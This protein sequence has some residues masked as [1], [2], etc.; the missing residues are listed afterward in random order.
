[1]SIL[2]GCAQQ[3]KYVS[4]TVKRGET[5]K[6]IAKDNGMKS[7]DLLRLNPDVSKRPA[8]N[9]V[10]IIPNKNYNP[11]AEEVTGKTTHRVLRQE[12]LFSISQ[13]YGITVDALKEANDLIGNSISVGRVLIIPAKENVDLEEIQEV[14]IDSTLITHTV[15]KDD[16]IYNLTKLYEITEDELMEMN[17]TL[18]D[19]LN[20]GM[21]LIVGRI[22]EETEEDLNR[23]KDSIT[24]KQLNILLMLPYKLK[25]TTSVETLFEKRNSLLNIVTDFHSGALIAIDSLRSQGM[26]VN[27]DVVDTENNNNK[28]AAILR[29]T[30]FDEYDAVIGPLFLKNAKTVSRSV[31]IP[32]IAPIFSKTQTTVSDNNL[33]KVAPNKELLESKVMDYMLENYHGE[34][35]IVTGDASTATSS[36]IARVVAK[37]KSHD[38]INDVTVIRQEEGYIKKEKFIEAIDTVQYKNWVLLVGDDNITTADVVNNLGVMPLELRDIRLFSFAMGTNFNNVSNTHLVRLNFTYSDEEFIDELSV[39]TRSFERMYKAKNYVRPSYYATKGFDVTYDALLRLS[40]YDSFNE[41]AEAGVS[42]RVLTKF[43]YTKRWFGST[44]NLGVYLLQYQEGLE[45]KVIE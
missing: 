42:E 5:I 27:I 40:T 12:N 24:D 14:A 30:D 18:V 19:G 23:F 13:K 22:S 33:V 2:T 6:S 35:I 29:E 26:Y 10:I 44:E 8:E 31:S 28:I 20:L 32:V 39:K 45:L 9:T 38:S 41:G 11:D 17:P 21:V 7:K 15:V 1:M 25:D 34:K 37:L 4:Y 36:N 16:T 43:D 3:K